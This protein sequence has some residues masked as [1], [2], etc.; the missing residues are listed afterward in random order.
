VIGNEP[1]QEITKTGHGYL[2]LREIETGHGY[3][4][5]REI[6]TGHGYLCLREIVLSFDKL[7]YVGL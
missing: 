7:L 1:T 6:E 4:C 5:L 3:L 2:C